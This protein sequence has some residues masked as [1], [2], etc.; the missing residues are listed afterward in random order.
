MTTDRQTIDD[1]TPLGAQ[2]EELRGK[3]L[4][5]AIN[6][7]IFHPRGFALTFDQ[8]EEK[9]IVGVWVQGDGTECW[10]YAGEDDDDGFTKFESLLA[11][12]RG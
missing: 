1:E 11:E 5:W 4:L 8:N 12:L 2:L 3:G 7:Y 10:A 9:A 6:R